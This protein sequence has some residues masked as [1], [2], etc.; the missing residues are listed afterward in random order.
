VK[1]M[2]V[3]LRPR[4]AVLVVLGMIFMFP[5]IANAAPPR[6]GVV[7]LAQPD[8]STFQARV[9][10]D[11]HAHGM[12]TLA[13]YTILLDPQTHYWVYVVRSSAG[14]LTPALGPQGKLVVGKSNPAT[15]PKG[16]RP[17]ASLRSSAAVSKA[18]A[19][20]NAGTQKVLV[21]LVQFS[22]QPPI[23]TD[24]NHW[25]DLYFGATN[26]VAQYYSQVSYNQFHIAPA[27]ETF[28][29]VNNGVVGWLTLSGTFAA[30]MSN[31]QF[32]KDA[33]VEADPFVNYAAFDT[34]HDGSVSVDELHIAVVA[35]GYEFAYIVSS[36]CGTQN[37]LW[38]HE[39]A[40]DDSTAPVV[41]GVTV[42]SSLHNGA[43][44]TLGEWDCD[45]S[46]PPGYEHPA[47]IGLPTHELG[48]DLGLPDLYDVS[49]GTAGIG[50]WSIMSTGVWTT[51]G[52]LPGD[53]PAHP[54]AW[55]RWYEGWLTPALVSAPLLGQ[56][57]PQIE[58][59]PTVFLLPDNPNG[60]DWKWLTKSG[61][62]EYFLVEN[63]QK[64]LYDAGIPGCGLLIWHLDETVTSD[65]TANV[66]PNHRLVDLEQADGLRQ[67]NIGDGGNS[68]DTGDPY[69]GSTG[70]RTFSASSNPNSHFYSGLSSGVTISSISNCGSTMT[71]SF[72]S[73]SFFPAIGKHAP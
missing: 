20:V 26:S 1:T 66:N 35:A 29:T 57:I 37:T 12:E 13:G 47:T 2:L 11:E 33:I 7:T 10:G 51:N 27:E 21:I 30:E 65:N 68:G 54:D 14:V 6:P 56:S 3:A 49:Y 34:N 39:D 63:R 9:W 23:G 70:N 25:H 48:H 24:E 59:S 62:G 15:L 69:P 58:T 5:P 4:F 32:V 45:A 71:L 8:G 28:G 50:D 64:T 44:T 73:W 38:G 46:E 67:L 53:S 16:L 36:P 52:G 72:G 61:T 18:S 42:A 17:L 60:I 41:D 43:Y 19:Q 31:D 55:S 22:D 40:F